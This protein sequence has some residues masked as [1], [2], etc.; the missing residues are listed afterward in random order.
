MPGLPR[1]GIRPACGSPPSPGGPLF[2]RQGVGL[3]RQLPVGGR[4]VAGGTRGGYW[5]DGW[6]VRSTPC[7]ACG[8]CKHGC[9]IVPCLMPPQ[10]AGANTAGMP[11]PRGMGASTTVAS[12][13]SLSPGGCRPY[14]LYPRRSRQLGPEGHWIVAGGAAP[15]G[16]APGKRSQQTRAPTGRRR[17]TPAISVAP[18]GLWIDARCPG[19]PLPPWGRST[20]GYCP[21]SRWD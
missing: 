18:L 4:G 14:G 2:A 12:A 13:T 20:P 15:R 1:L 19:V 17:N 10:G 11:P 3:A 7:G 9:R 21:S 8:V 16:R 6:H 5:V